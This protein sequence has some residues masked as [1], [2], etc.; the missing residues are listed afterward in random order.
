MKVVVFGYRDWSFRIFERLNVSKKYLVNCNDY[1]VLRAMK[2]DLVFFIGWSHI[3]PEWVIQEFVCIC[4][5]PSPLPLYRGGSPIQHQIINGETDSAVSLFIMD[6]GLDTGDLVFQQSFSLLGSLD[7]IFD[8]I[9]EI[10]SIGVN[11]VCQN[12][13]N[14]REKAVKQDNNK[15]T[16]YKRRK[17]EESEITFDEIL[18]SSPKKLHDKIRSLSDPYPNA[19]IKCKEGKKLYITDSKFEE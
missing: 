11:E 2:P 9:V 8:R 17:P 3:V 4:L 15:A 13:S 14:L 5:H 18:N 12:A 16:L 19:F 7:A 6:K 1:E 10:G